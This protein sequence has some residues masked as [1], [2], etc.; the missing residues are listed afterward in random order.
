MDEVYVRE[1]EDRP[2]HGLFELHTRASTS[3]ERAFTSHT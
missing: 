2:G 3:T 1:R